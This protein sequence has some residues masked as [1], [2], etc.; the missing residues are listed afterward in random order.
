MRNKYLSKI[1]LLTVGLVLLATAAFAGEELKLPDKPQAWVN[2]YAHVLSSGQLQQLNNRLKAL[3]Q[4]SSNQI[5]IAIFKKMP[6][7]TYLEDFAVKLYDKWRPGLKDENNGLL[8]VIFTDDRKIRF[9]VGYGLED[10]L[11]DAYSKRIISN[12]IAPYFRKQDYFGGLNSALDVVIP[13]VEKKYQIPIKTEK[14]SSG[15]KDSFGGLVIALI[16]LFVM[17]RFFGGGSGGIGTRRRGGFISGMFIGSMLGGGSGGF[18]GGGGGGFGGGFGGFS[19]GGG[20]S[21]GW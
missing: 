11:T 8:I 21:G 13:A 18:S 7:S 12:I 9:E 3:Q 16:I 15:K 2:D 5:F 4:R 1:A 19:G 6:E 20:A 17:L 10:V 14:K